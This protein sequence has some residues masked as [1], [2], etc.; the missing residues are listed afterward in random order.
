ML[1]PLPGELTDAV[2]AQCSAVQRSMQLLPYYTFNIEVSREQHGSR[3]GPS[4]GNGRTL[5]A[6]A[7]ILDYLGTARSNR[8]RA[9]IIRTEPKWTMLNLFRKTPRGGDICC[10][11][12]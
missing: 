4:A 1:L 6:K 10:C 11:Y 5:L 7:H 9:H 3:T 2:E 8:A 12:K